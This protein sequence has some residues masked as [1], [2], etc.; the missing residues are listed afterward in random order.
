MHRARRWEVTHSLT[1]QPELSLD[2]DYRI[3][4]P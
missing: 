4:I 3:D 1:P 2:V